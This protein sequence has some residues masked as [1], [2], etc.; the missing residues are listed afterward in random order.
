MKTF[1]TKAIL[2]LS[3]NLS[4]SQQWFGSSN[5]IYTNNNVAVGTSDS[6]YQISGYTGYFKFRM[7][8][9]TY[10]AF[11]PI[12]GI[13]PGILFGK[14]SDT[15]SVFS[16]SAIGLSTSNGHYFT[17]AVPND[18]CFRSAVGGSIIFGALTTSSTDAEQMRIFNNGMVRINNSLQIGTR[19]IPTGYNLSV[20]GKIICNELKVRL[21]NAWP[22]YVFEKN[23]ELK[24]IDELDQFIKQNK[25]LPN[26]PSAK[27]VEANGIDIGEMN[28]KLIEKVE[29]LTLYVIELKKEIDVIKK[30]HQ[31]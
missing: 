23:Y 26:I 3:I 29:E 18:F 6:S 13:A 11:L 12:T 7:H 21:S 30:D 2:L 16:G 5:G 24:S 27:E 9:D 25:H 31:K 17:N 20:D 14:N 10:A 19:N 28:R 1:F 8:S 4:L 15:N 22:D